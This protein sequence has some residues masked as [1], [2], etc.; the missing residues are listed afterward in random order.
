MRRPWL[1]SATFRLVVL[2]VLLQVLAVGAVLVY[3]RFAIASQFTR[4]QQLIVSELQSDLLAWQRSGGTRAIAGEIDRR[5]NSLKGENIVV[6]LADKQGTRI[7]GN[8]E[9]W[10]TVVPWVTDWRKIELYRIGSDRSESLGVK[11]VGLP[12]G[13]H[14]LTGRVIEGDVRFDDVSARVMIAAFLLAVPLALLIAAILSRFIERRLGAI[15]DTAAAVGDGDLARRVPLDQSGDGFDLLAA[16]VNAMLARIETLVSELRIVTGGL[17]HDLRTP[18]MRLTATIEQAAFEVRDPAAVKALDKAAAEAG[19]LMAMLSTAMQISQAEA[20]IGRNRF[21]DVDI[22]EM[23]SDIAELYEP[24]LEVQGLALHITA[25]PIHRRLHRELVSQAIG[26]LID[27]AMK[28]AGGATRIDVF[29]VATDGRL[30]LVVADDGPGIAPIDRA[31]AL[32]RFGR[33]DPSRHTSGAGL[34]LSLVEAVARLHDGSV[35]LG[36]NHP[37]LRVSMVLN[38]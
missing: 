2:M 31:A 16:K 38:C 12:G 20:G 29:A 32:R 27:N 28:Y 22:A 13:G 7:A 30:E 34:G 25:A 10:P 26:N 36:D 8:L 33:H 21:V 35:E 6:L 23:L 17:A 11:A 37:G 15:A 19:I 1:G 3:V 18:I 24:A 5:L 9:S 14:L 4:D